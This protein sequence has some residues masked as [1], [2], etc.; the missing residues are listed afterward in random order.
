MGAGIRGENMLVMLFS[1]VR[2]PPTSCRQATDNRRSCNGVGPFAAF[3]PLEEGLPDFD[4]LVG[5][6]S[7]RNHADSEGIVRLYAYL[8]APMIVE[9]LFVGRNLQSAE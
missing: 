9:K 7:M 5:V 4:R 8:L 3:Q 1:P 2:V 6:Q